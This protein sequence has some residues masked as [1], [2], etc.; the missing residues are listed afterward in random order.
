MSTRDAQWMTSMGDEVPSMA[1]AVPP[2]I[3]LSS[4]K[5]AFVKMKYLTPSTE[6]ENVL[7]DPAFKTAMEK[8]FPR[9][10]ESQFYFELAFIKEDTA[11]KIVS[12]LGTLALFKG[13]NLLLGRIA[14]LGT[15]GLATARVAGLIAAA[16]VVVQAVD[17]YREY[18]AKTHP[19][20]ELDKRVIQELQRAKQMNQSSIDMIQQSI[21]EDPSTKALW[22]P[23]MNAALRQ[24]VKILTKLQAKACS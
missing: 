6:L 23:M 10:Q 5:E 19:T 18:R 8:C 7:D 3:F 9:D 12:G 22:L 17:T 20:C 2:R 1:V 14:T 21:S 11:G 13:T 16:S 24:R 15:V 4:A